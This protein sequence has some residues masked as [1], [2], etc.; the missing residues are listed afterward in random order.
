[1]Q[2][3]PVMG[4][5][6]EFVGYEFKQFMLNFEHILAG[7]NGGAIGN[8][9]YMRIHRDG[10]VSESSIQHHIGGLATHAGQ[11]FQRFA[12]LRYLAAVLFQQYFAGLHDMLGLGFIKTYALYIPAQFFFA[13]VEYRLRGIGDRVKLPGGGIHAYI[14]CLS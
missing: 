9:E 14:R 7:R 1:M 2:Y 13:Q 4:V 8:A 11:C 3:Q 12:R 6:L 5:E 10:G